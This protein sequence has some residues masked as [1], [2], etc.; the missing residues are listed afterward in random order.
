MKSM[1]ITAVGIDVSK[2]KSTVAIRR[3]GGV[4][5]ACPFDI[6]HSSHDL[7]KLVSILK[8]TGGDIRVV[9]EHT[10]N[11]WK[12]IA[13][14]LKNAGFYVSVV[15]AMLIHDFSDNSIRKLKTDRADSL[16]IANYALTFWNQ[17]PPFNDED[18]TR[19][20]LKEQS[21][22]YERLASTATSLRNGLIALA[23][24]TFP[25]IDQAFGHAIKNADGHE[26][27]VDFFSIYWHRDCVLRLSIEKF[28]E[29][30]RKWCLRRNYKFRTNTAHKL[31]ALAQ[32]AVPT[33]PKNNGTKALVLQACKS[34]NAVCE[35][36]QSTQEEMN[37][38]ASLL[39]EYEVVMQME[40]TGPI[41][42]PALMAEIGDVRRFKNK[43][44]LV[45]FAGIDAPPFQSGNFESKSRHVSK[46][47]SPHLRRTVFLV[48]NIIL[49]LSHKDNSVFCFMDK[50]RAEGKHYYVYTIAGSAKFL[51]IYYAR[52]SEYLRT[53]E[54][55]A[56]AIC[57]DCKDGLQRQRS[58]G[59]SVDEVLKHILS[60]KGHLQA[61]DVPCYILKITIYRSDD[62]MVDKFS[63]VAGNVP[64]TNNDPNRR[65]TVINGY[66]VVLNFAKEPNPGVFE[67][68]RDILL[69]T[70][71]TKKTS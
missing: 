65:Y 49:T 70:S 51:R 41:T 29:S 25:S 38:L 13:L 10:S 57:L 30:Y 44:A 9:M 19:L 37:R 62:T 26:K 15:N 66:P 36:K 68:V 16:K 33:L 50:K 58:Q 12:P 67:R 59:R 1:E 48:A 61:A 4:I 39:P 43:K 56:A 2:R 42:G 17:L 54:P 6:S 52:V 14:T 22:M 40:G 7:E 45:A 55:P 34:L 28:T 63:Q 21:R 53:Q 31:Y 5:V 24:Q 69:A 32:D 11:Y 71:Y 64:V 20:V 23:D 46:R 8:T 60:A 47:G 35:A 3:P 27:W 18:E